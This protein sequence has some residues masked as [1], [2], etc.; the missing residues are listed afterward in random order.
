MRGRGCHPVREYLNALEHDGQPRLATWLSTIFGAKANDYTKL[1]GTWWPV[2]AV[3]RIFQ[4]GASAKYVLTLEG[5]QDLG[6][7]TAL[8]RL[9]GDAWFS[10][11]EMEVG[12]LNGMLGLQG[13]WIQEIAEGSILGKYQANQLKGWISKTSDHVVKKLSNL[14]SDVPR[15]CT[16]AMTINPL[17]NNGYLDDPTGAVRFWP[18]AITKV[19]F[20]ALDRDRD[21]LWAEAVAMYR[22]GTIPEPRTAQDRRLLGVEQDERRAVD[23]WEGGIAGWL[24]ERDEATVEDIARLCLD[25]EEQDYDRKVQVRIVSVLTSLGWRLSPKRPLRDDGK[26]PKVY[27]P[28]VDRAVTVEPRPVSPAEELLLAKAKLLGWTVEIDASGNHAI[29]QPPPAPPGQIGDDELSKMV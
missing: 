10:D 25:I 18:V 12:S 19:D 20:D 28:P 15:Q 3:R 5:P 1:V 8:R 22:A 2:Q 26:R 7:S 11:T 23:M 27:L 6:K 16:F 24:A 29:V 9:C 13:V 4:P 17:S 21:Q 14:A